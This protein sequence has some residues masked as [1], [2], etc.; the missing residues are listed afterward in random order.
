MKLYL[1]K[2]KDYKSLPQNFVAYADYRMIRKGAFYVRSIQAFLRKKYAKE[3][4]KERKYKDLYEI[5]TIDSDYG[6][7]KTK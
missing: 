2:H 6:I 3:W 4:I 5:V 7:V 1:I